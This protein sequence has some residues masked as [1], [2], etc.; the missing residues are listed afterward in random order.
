[1]TKQ[2]MINQGKQQLQYFYTLK[3]S[4]ARRLKEA[5]YNSKAT[6]ALIDKVLQESVLPMAQYLDMKYDKITIENAM[7]F[8]DEDG[9][10]Y[11]RA[12]R[13]KINKAL[14]SKGI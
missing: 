13:I 2:E 1:M 9:M 11:Y 4:V 6:D 8:M 10:A 5:G 3:R 7:T 14:E 12:L